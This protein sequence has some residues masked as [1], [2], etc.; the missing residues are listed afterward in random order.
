MVEVKVVSAFRGERPSFGLDRAQICAFTNAAFASPLVAL[1]FQ[2][3]AYLTLSLS[4]EGMTPKLLS[5][6]TNLPA[7]RSPASAAALACGASAP[8]APVAPKAGG[9]RR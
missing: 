5:G 8:T 4:Y 7:A 3:L 6:R 9:K 1:G 2:Q